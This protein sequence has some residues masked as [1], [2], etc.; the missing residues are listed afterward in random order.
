MTIHVIESPEY[1][2]DANRLMWDEGI[3][4]MA[5]SLRQHN[6]A[7]AFLN[8]PDAMMKAYHEANRRGIKFRFIGSPHRALTAL[9]QE[10]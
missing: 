2:E 7:N 8:D 3:I 5:H 10:D 4:E 1:G 9:L 6:Q